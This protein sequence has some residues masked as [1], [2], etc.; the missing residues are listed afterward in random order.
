[1]TAATPA[2]RGLY[3]ILDLP[4]AGGLAPEEAA[5]GLVGGGAGPAIVQLRA[6]HASGGE[7]AALVRV[8]APL[9]RAAGALL[10]VNDDV[11]AAL[12]ADGVHLGQADLAARA[13]G[14]GWPVVVA[15]LRRLAPPGFVIGLST[16]TRAQ[17]EHGAGLD[18]D[19]IGFGPVLPTYSKR[20][21]EPCV[22]FDELQRVCEISPH[23]VVAIGGLGPDDALR[24]I[25]LGAAGAAMIG[26]L[27]AGSVDEVQ[28]RVAGPAA[29]LREAALA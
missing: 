23:P 11:E 25:Q 24:C 4:H 16:H 27:V 10:V 14:R 21:P 20:A 5:R 2:W 9:V 22:G 17:V 8:L 26:A 18:L 19:Y 29:A 7:R 12:A 13:G 3:A 6:K 1:M 15:E 28:R